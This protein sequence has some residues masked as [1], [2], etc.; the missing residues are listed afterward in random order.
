[1]V[2]NIVGDIGEGN[3]DIVLFSSVNVGGNLFMNN[4]ICYIVM[5]VN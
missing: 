4:V 1:M 3:D 5:I 2:I